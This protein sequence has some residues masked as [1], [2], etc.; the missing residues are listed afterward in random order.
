MRAGK[1]VTER[2]AEQVT[3]A[4]GELGTVRE[5]VAEGTKRLIRTGTEDARAARKNLSQTGFKA[6]EVDFGQLGSFVKSSYL[7]TLKTLKDN[8]LGLSTQLGASVLIGGAVGATVY[9]E[10]R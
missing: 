2:I 7:S 3:G 5:N 10:G 6:A 1:K 8:T 9:R 4:V